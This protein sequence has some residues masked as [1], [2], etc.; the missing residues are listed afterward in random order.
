M[1]VARIGSL[2]KSNTR[3]CTGISSQIS[4]SVGIRHGSSISVILTQ[5]HPTLGSK[6]DL[7]KVKR[8]FARNLLVPRKIAGMS[9][10]LLF[11]HIIS[12]IL[13]SN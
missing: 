11:V 2:Y 8:G 1:N 3:S 9:L 4:R 12:Y 10:I 7:V 6:G 13:H 5:A